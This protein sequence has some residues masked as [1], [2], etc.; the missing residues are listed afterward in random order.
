MTS[1]ELAHATELP[2]W[3]QAVGD[4]VFDWWVAARRLECSTQLCTL[5]GLSRMPADPLA[6]L[7]Q[8]IH[9]DDLSALQLALNACWH[10]ADGWLRHECRVRGGDGQERWMLIRG[11]LLERDGLGAP[12]HVRG[13]LSDIS[14]RKADEAMLRRYEH[15]VATSSDAMYFVDADCRIVLANPAMTIRFGLTPEQVVGRPMATVFGLVVF[16]ELSHDLARALAGEAMHF[17]RW[18]HYPALGRRFVDVHYDPCGQAGSPA[19]GVVVTVRDLTDSARQALLLAQT[20][21]AAHIG[22]WEI[23]C[24]RQEV[25]WTEEMF[26]LLGVPAG[27]ARA[28]FPAMVITHAGSAMGSAVGRPG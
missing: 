8:R 17:Q 13:V 25:F 11:Q 15:I 16:D 2:D 20:Q 23:D 4:V 18:M 19:H 7:N 26:C 5:L 12:R 22:G 6:E 9:P 3:Q 14:A 28:N 24:Q 27:F 21:R 1:R 10:S